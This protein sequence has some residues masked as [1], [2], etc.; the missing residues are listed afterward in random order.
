[1][2]P[3]PDKLNSLLCTFPLGEKGE[4]SS[5]K[6]VA[7]KSRPGD[8][9]DDDNAGAV[10][11]M[12]ISNPDFYECIFRLEPHGSLSPFYCVYLDPASVPSSED[13][14]IPWAE[15]GI[16][17]VARR[18]AVQ[19]WQ[20]ASVVGLAISGPAARAHSFWKTASREPHLWRIYIAW[21]AALSASSWILLADDQ[22]LPPLLST[23]LSLIVGLGYLS[24]LI[25]PNTQTS[26]EGF[27]TRHREAILSK[28]SAENA[29]RIKPVQ[30][31]SYEVYDLANRAYR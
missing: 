31:V 30:P 27:W 28:F 7:M 20:V 6:L 26:N 29:S 1:M 3:G 10:A 17:L 14:M 11:F 12:K 18:R 25:H 15:P 16:K 13:I 5:L 22:G 21:V 24:G 23:R 2:L 8:R 19:C 9:V 4:V